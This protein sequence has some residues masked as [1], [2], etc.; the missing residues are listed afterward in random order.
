MTIDRE[1][2]AYH[3]AGHAVAAH[4]FELTVE[5]ISIE[6]SGDAA[7][8]VVHDYGCKMNEIIYEDGPKKQW[9]LERA[10][11]CTLAGEVAQRRFRAESVSEEHGGGDREHLHLILDLLAGE[12]DQELRNAWE[13]LLVL[14]TERLIDARWQGVDWVAGLLLKHTKI[15]GAEEIRHAIADA[16]LPMEY[17]G[18]HLSF[19]DRLALSVGKQPRTAEGE[20][21]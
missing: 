2:V 4:E 6:P 14:R 20:Q 18:K 17:R 11:I 13:T 16:E 7:G 15:E 8:H 1:T 19:S 21:A 9:A 10:A 3:E 5:R 12:Q